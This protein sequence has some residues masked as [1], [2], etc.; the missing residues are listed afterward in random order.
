M[1]IQFAQALGQLPPA[2][3]AEL[4]TEYSKITRNYR[5]RRWEAA[6]LD[7]GRLC[8]VVYTILDGFLKGGTYASSA[9]KPNNFKV[10]CEQLAQADKKVY[11][12]SARVTLPLALV[13][14]YDLRNNRGVGHVGGDVDA[15]HMDATLVLHMSQWIMA[16][17]VR[18]FHN[19]SV[20]EA[21]AVVEALVD[22]TVPALWEVDD[23]TRVLDPAVTLADGTLLL[24]YSKATSTPEADLARSLE[25]D[26]LPNYRRVLTRLHGQRLIEYNSTTRCATISPLGVKDVEERLLKT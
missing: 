5:E 2:L 9:S 25:Q 17:L 20:G 3:R 18:L 6:E 24:L 21:T 19:V 8:E 1:A 26:K 16:E 14:L 13:P 22:R 7:G 12:K 23:V 11:P 10:A 15:N 4:L